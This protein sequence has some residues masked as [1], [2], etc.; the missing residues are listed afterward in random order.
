L[1]E[2]IDGFI[3]GLRH[4]VTVAGLNYEIWWTYKEEESRK[5]YAA[6]MN[7]YSLFFQSSLHAHFVALIVAL[8]GLY[9]NNPHTVNIPALL[10]LIKDKHPFSAETEAAVLELSEKAQRSFSKVAIL[11]NN[12][13]GHHSAKLSTQEVFAKAGISP[14][15]IK[16]LID[17]TKQL[18]NEITH[19]WNKSFHAFNLGARDST[20]K[21]LDD[22][23]ELPF[24]RSP[25]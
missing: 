23:T 7:R 1:K 25:R 22:L 11:R 14:N 24:R 12:A 6:T 10:R 9:E 5:K 2:K 3:S 15:D 19:D 17:T 13:F 18:L 8:Y 16:E 4:A 21:L 20:L